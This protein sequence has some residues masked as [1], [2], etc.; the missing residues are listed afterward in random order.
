MG[1]KVSK[2]KIKKLGGWHEACLYIY[3][4]GRAPPREWASESGGFIS[5]PAWARL[6]L[7]FM[8][9]GT[10]QMLPPGGLL[11][12]GTASP[13]QIFRLEKQP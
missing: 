9:Y 1:E 8:V 11:N 3:I 7:L 5:C 13:K 2:G 12:L 10:W 6:L 4:H